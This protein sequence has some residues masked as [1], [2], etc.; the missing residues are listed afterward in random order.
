MG[1]LKAI[2]GVLVGAFIG[3]LIGGM[4]GWAR[5]IAASVFGGLALLT[6]LIM[7]IYKG[8][9]ILWPG[10]GDWYAASSY[11]YELP[12]ND[13]QRAIDKN[14]REQW[15]SSDPQEED[16]WFE[17]DMGKPRMIASIEF[18]ADDSDVEKPAKW[19]M[20]FYGKGR[21][22]LSHKDG[23]GFIYVE[24]N[25]IPNNTQYF[26][27]QIKE[28]AQDMPAG[29]N[30]AKRNLTTKVYWTISFIRIQEHRFSICGKRFC[31]H[32]V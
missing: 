4:E 5:M 19:R 28:T 22:T 29:S 32:E 11:L 9:M 21:R 7:G 17:V 30:Y 18:L 2:F 27:A 31:I 15:H 6:L 10:R 16:A 25:D 1:W 8:C 26:R 3:A 23:D 14:R 12:P 13:P 24:G 20:M